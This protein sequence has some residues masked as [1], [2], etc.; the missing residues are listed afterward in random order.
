MLSCV[1]TTI[2]NSTRAQQS[3]SLI[4]CEAGHDAFPSPMSSCSPQRP[5]S[6]F[7]I[8]IANPR[9][10]SRLSSNHASQLQI[11]NRERM[12]ICRFTPSSRPALLRLS[13]ATRQWL[14]LGRPRVNGGSLPTTFLIVTPRLESPATPTKQNTNPI[15]NRYK[16]PFFAPLSRSALITRYS[17]L[18]SCHPA[19]APVAPTSRKAIMSR[20]HFTQI[21]RSEPLMRKVTNAD[22][23]QS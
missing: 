4:T 7:R 14:V 19:L 13:L 1:V 10:E 9:L 17:S 21:P 18:V 8:V 16:S 3:A 15:S 11:S 22:P 2:Q 23:N 20:N 6:T 12:A 5:I